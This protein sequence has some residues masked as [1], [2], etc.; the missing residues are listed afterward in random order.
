ME[1]PCP[2]HTKQK[3]VAKD[4]FTLKKYVEEH[5]KHPARNQDGSDRN[6]DQQPDSPAFLD[7]EHQLNM[8]Y[9]G[10]VA[11]ESKRKQKLT[12]REINAVTP[13][14]SKYLKWS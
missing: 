12:A 6:K 10:S 4:Y 3:H 14:T 9:G 13:V 7:L 2:F 5:S 8:I 11:Y 1:S